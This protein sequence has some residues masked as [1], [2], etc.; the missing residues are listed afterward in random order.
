MRESVEDKVLLLRC[1]EGQ[2]EALREFDQQY[3]QR[4]YD[5]LCKILG[6]HSS[7]NQNLLLLSFADAFKRYHSESQEG[8]FLLFVLRALVRRA[9]RQKVGDFVELHEKDDLRAESILRALR[10]LP[11]RER[12][13]ILLR[14]QMDLL[15][16]EIA[17]VLSASAAAVKVELK[18]ARFSLR[19]KITESMKDY[20]RELQSGSKANP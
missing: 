7:R 10:S 9:A 2:K 6:C 14:T 4:I 13:L 17:F 19:K 20:Y 8:S 16:E 5:F 1:L 15:Y 18:E 12:V 3:G 11:F